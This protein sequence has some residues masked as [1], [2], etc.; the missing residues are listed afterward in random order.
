MIRRALITGVS[1]ALGHALSAAL[2][3]RH[4]EVVGV[5]RDAAAPEGCV[6]Y[7]AGDI[8]TLDWSPVLTGCDAVFHLAAFVHR[9]PTP[10]EIQL[11]HDVNHHATSKLARAARMAGCKLVFVSTVAVLGPGASGLGDDAPLA[12]TTE[13]GMSKARAEAAIAAE[14]E[15]GLS[16]AVLRMPLLYGPRGRGNMERMLGAIAR[17][18]YWP[19]GDSRTMKSCLHFADAA[20]ALL[21]AVGASLGPGPYVV[22]PPRPATLGEIHDAAYRAVSAAAPAFSIPTGLATVFA[23]AADWSAS[24]VGRRTRLRDQIAT[25]TSPAWYDGSR[26]IAA[27]GFAPRVDLRTGLSLTAEWMR[28]TNALG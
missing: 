21:L 24:L 20:E 15:A 27:T 23:G 22:A 7:H 18:R 10:A 2:R 25:L 16:A 13:Y 5:D 12:P 6:R 17:R 4:V 1:G 8:T 26:F 11:V 19:V 14:A 28:H 9:A 3:E